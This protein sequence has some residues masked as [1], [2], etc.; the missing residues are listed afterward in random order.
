MVSMNNYLSIKS[1][2]RLRSISHIFKDFI[3]VKKYSFYRIFKQ[4]TFSPDEIIKM[5]FKSDKLFLENE[6]D[7]LYFLSITNHK[8]GFKLKEYVLNTVYYWCIMDFAE[9]LA[10]DHIQT[11]N[12]SVNDA[13]YE[14]ACIHTEMYTDYK[15]LQGL[16]IELCCNEYLI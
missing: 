2:A 13:I 6:S 9:V 15:P 1:A 16:L 10:E 8:Y 5:L 4:L 7:E 14:L 11:N 12:I 3:I